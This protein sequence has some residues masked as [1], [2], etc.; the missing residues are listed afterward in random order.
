MVKKVSDTEQ[1]VDLIVNILIDKKAR[2]VVVLNISQKSSIADY[3]VIANG[4]VARHVK[5]LADEVDE[6]VKEK[7]KIKLLRIDGLA[8]RIG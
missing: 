8:E 2:D 6:Q 7:K 4:E 1:L 5:A 3:F